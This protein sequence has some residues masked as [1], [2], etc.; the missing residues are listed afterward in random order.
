MRQK[1]IF[2][3]TRTLYVTLGILECSQKWVLL[4]HLRYHTTS[5]CAQY[6]P[7]NEVIFNEDFN[8]HLL[9]SP[10]GKPA[11]TIPNKTKINNKQM[12]IKYNYRAVVC[13]FEYLQFSVCVCVYV[14]VYVCVC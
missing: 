11:K 6:Q 7:Y 13:V 5:K 1:W 3:T 9:D 12:L 2:A 8:K 4:K 10:L 14:C